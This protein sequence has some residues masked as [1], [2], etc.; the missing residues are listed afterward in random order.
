M[1]ALRNISLLFCLTLIALLLSD[2]GACAIVAEQ[3]SLFSQSTA[4]ALDR[5]FANPDFSFLLLDVKSGRVLA[6]R[7]ENPDVPI[8]VGSLV[9]PFTALAYGE[10]HGFAY[11]EHVCRGTVT[12][13]WRPRGHGRVNL[14]TAIA[15]S[16]NSYFEML[17]VTLNMHQVSLTATQF[18]I[19]SPAS[20][21][22]ETA[23]I[24]IG[25]QW[26]VSPARLSRA[27]LELLHRRRQPGVRTILSGMAMSA[28]QGTGA[29]VDRTLLRSEAL[30]KTGTAP[31]THAKRAPGDGFVLTLWPAD[32]P[33]ILLL[34]RVHGVPG[35]QAA[36]TAGEILNRVGE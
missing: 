1:V 15:Y 16:C 3:N 17:A 32:E 10:Q 22:S 4:E 25:D 21:A 8:P 29:A 12:G 24:G 36:K 35:A 31:C 26:L 27:Y 34:V 23:L 7:W 28:R 30:V 13:C 5:D 6:S 2:A 33:R 18:G 11:P 14:I 19:Q 20:S 9:K